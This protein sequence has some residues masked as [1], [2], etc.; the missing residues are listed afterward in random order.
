MSEQRNDLK[1][2]RAIRQGTEISGPEFETQKL[3][4]V[5]LLAQNGKELGLSVEQSSRIVAFWQL[6]LLGNQTQNLTKLTSSDGFYFG[7]LIDVIE[8]EKSNLLS[9]DLMDLGSGCGV[10][11]LLHAIIFKKNKWI[12]AES[13]KSKAEFLADTADKMGLSHNLVEIIPTRAELFLQHREID[14]VVCRAVGTISK[15]LT[16]IGPCSTWNRLVL[17]KGPAWDS[18]WAEFKGQKKYITGKMHEY[19][20]GA[21]NKQRKIVEVLRSK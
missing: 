20:V 18:E 6:L 1:V 11:G 19:K 9:G 4:L 21:E 13:E 12:L 14:V 16:W 7:H 10:P 2:V 8:L 17:L 3:K 15:I 5:E